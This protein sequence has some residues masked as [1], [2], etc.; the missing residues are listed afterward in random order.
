MQ[1]MLSIGEINVYLKYHK[2]RYS[3]ITR[4]INVKGLKQKYAKSVL[5][6]KSE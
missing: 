4:L 6:C 5:L 3:I 2:A 1:D